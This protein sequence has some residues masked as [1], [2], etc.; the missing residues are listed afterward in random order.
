MFER[1]NLLCNNN[2]TKHKKSNCYWKLQLIVVFS[3]TGLFG[4]N[5]G[6]KKC[7][8]L[9]KKQACEVKLEFALM[10]TF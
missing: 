10:R 1:S 6:G 9:P 7:K 5:S 3:S 2:G 4:G 8:Q